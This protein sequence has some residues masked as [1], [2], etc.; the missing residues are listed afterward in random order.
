ME[1]CQP[2]EVPLWRKRS[3]PKAARF[4]KK[5]EDND[6]NRYLFSELMLFK[7]FTN[8]N[9]IGSQDEIKCR[10]I[11]F[12][13]KEA[14]Q[15]VEQ[16]LLPFAKGIEE[17]SYFVE[18]AQNDKKE[19]NRKIG[20]I[21][22]AEKEQEILECQ[23]AEYMHPDFTH[24]NPDELDIQ[25]NVTQIKKSFRHIEMK[26]KDQILEETRRL[27]KYQKKSAKQDNKICSRCDSV[28]KRNYFKTKAPIYFCTRLFRLPLGMTKFRGY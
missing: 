8:E 11:Y 9:K 19:E 7:G 23:D 26:D 15:E 14:L 10:D 4:H 28:K 2:G 6:L 16:S 20:A 18:I 27:D 3:F 12:K 25:R 13:H 5:R 1:N 24:L 21:L 17:A 22:D